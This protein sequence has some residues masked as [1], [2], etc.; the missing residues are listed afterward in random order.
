MEA[1]IFI[2]VL[3]PQS[4]ISDPKSVY[5]LVGSGSDDGVDGVVSGAAAP[6]LPFLVLAGG[7]AAGA[8]PSVVGAASAD[9]FFRPPLLNSKQRE[10]LNVLS[11]GLR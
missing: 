4:K 5:C 9:F 2:I 6:F 8:D 1:R 10:K 11:S 3:L 7:V